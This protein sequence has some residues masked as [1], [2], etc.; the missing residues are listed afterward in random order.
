MEKGKSYSMSD[1]V[2]ELSTLQRIH[3]AKCKFKN[4]AEINKV[5]ENADDYLII[6]GKFEGLYSSIAEFIKAH[7]SGADK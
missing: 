4:F 6:I 1:P 3:A 7:G 2:K 5:S